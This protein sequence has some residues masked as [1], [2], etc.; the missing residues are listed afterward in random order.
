MKIIKTTTLASIGC[1][2]ILNSA[3]ACGSF[4]LGKKKD[5]TLLSEQSIGEKDDSTQT[6]VKERR[7]A[8]KVEGMTCGSCEF[9]VRRALKKVQGV[10][11][12]K[13]SVK[14]GKS[15]IVYDTSMAKT[16]D[17]IDAVNK[18]GY[19]A[20]LADSSNQSR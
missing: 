12:V 2:V 7:I 16:Q 19:K 18:A 20:S 9:H 4:C 10:K 11:E 14:G 1:V 15:D 3:W 17:L 5:A 6:V 8:L 13:V